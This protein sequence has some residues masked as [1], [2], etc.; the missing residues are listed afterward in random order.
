M[1]EQGEKNASC[2]ANEGPSYPICWQFE[3]DCHNQLNFTGA[4]SKHIRS[5]KA[6]NARLPAV[7][8]G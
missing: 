1:Q 7:T 6:E 2:H 3:N 8:T 5:E 4:G